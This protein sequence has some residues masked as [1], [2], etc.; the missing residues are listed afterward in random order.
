MLYHARNLCCAFI[1]LAAAIPAFCGDVTGNGARPLTPEQQVF[2]D[3]FLQEEQIRRAAENHS[4]E[5]DS[6]ERYFREGRF[7]E[8]LA[9]V[10]A[11]LAHHPHHQRGLDLQRDLIAVTTRACGMVRTIEDF[12]RDRSQR[13]N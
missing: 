1:A 9:A 2:W 13:K 3:G 12:L 10:R 6:A 4:V 5:Y 7:A 11:H 8:A